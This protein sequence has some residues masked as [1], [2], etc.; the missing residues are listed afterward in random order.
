M[1]GWGLHDQACFLG[2]ILEPK[3]P[4]RRVT[5]NL[6]DPPVMFALRLVDSSA[7]IDVYEI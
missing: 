1:V 3:N 7:K 5:L 6:F 2:M 4:P